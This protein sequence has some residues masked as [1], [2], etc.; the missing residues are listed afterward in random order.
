MKTPV[1][2]KAEPT[3]PSYQEEDSS[4]SMYSEDH[5]MSE[6]EESVQE[7]SPP[8]DR[9]SA[10]ALTVPRQSTPPEDR[11]SHATVERTLAQYAPRSL[12]P[13]KQAYHLPSTMPTKPPSVAKP[14]DIINP[15]ILED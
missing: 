6:S 15:W 9:V 14:S 12:A 11:D 13:T 3:P 2:P 8:R 4:V 5:Q 7:C 10:Y 1:L